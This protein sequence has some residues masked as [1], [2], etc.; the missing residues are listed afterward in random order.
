MFAAYTDKTETK[1]VISSVIIYYIGTQ[2]VQIARKREQNVN[3][4]GAVRY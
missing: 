4:A 2:F 1:I 3:S